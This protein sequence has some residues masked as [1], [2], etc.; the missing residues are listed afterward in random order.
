MDARDRRRRR[1]AEETA[2]MEAGLRANQTYIDAIANAEAARLALE[3]VA[4]PEE[5]V[6]TGAPTTSSPPPTRTDGET[7]EKNVTPS[8]HDRSASKDSA[9]VSG[10]AETKPEC[11]E[12]K[13][14]TDI[15][16]GDGIS[17]TIAI[18][19]PLHIKH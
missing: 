1:V 19:E 16:T 11:Q 12:P 18:P 5:R 14:N 10:V 13:N 7:E 9:P 6:E 3:R 17:S 2:R 15:P 8:D 4:A